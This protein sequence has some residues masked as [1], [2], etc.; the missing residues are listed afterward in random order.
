MRPPPKAKPQDSYT[1]GRENP[2]FAGLLRG[3]DTGS[4]SISPSTSDNG[5]LRG[6]RFS[7]IP[8]NFKDLPAKDPVSD[9]LEPFAQ[10]TLGTSSQIPRS[11][12]FEFQSSQSD[13]SFDLGGSNHSAKESSPDTFETTG[14]HQ[15]VP[16]L[17]R[18][19]VERSFVL[20][21]RK[22]NLSKIP[23]PQSAAT[24]YNGF[25]PQLEILESCESTVRLNLYLKARKDDVSA[26]VPG[27]FLHAV[28]GQDV[29][30]VGSIASTI[31]YALYLNET[32][33]SDQL[34]TVPIINMKRSG[35]SSHAEIKWLLDSCHIDESSL[36]FV[37]EID[38]SYFDLFGCLKLVLV[39]G[40]KLPTRQEALK[41][42]VIEVFNCRKGESVYPWVETVTIDQAIASA[43]D[44]SCCSLIAE[45]FFLTSPELLAGQG[46][47]RLLLAGILMDTGNLTSPHCTTKDKYMA[48][49]LLN[50][51]GRFGSS[52]LYQIMRYKMHDI[53]D[54]K[55]VDILR[56]DFKKWTRGGKPN[57][58][59]SR[60]V[61]SNI[62]MSSIGISLELFLAHERSSKEEIKY[63][64]Q[65]E[66]L[67]LLM[68]VS[69][70]YDDERNF[71]RE[72]LVSAESMELMRNL[73][74]FFNS[75]ASHMPLKAMHMSGLRDDMKAFEID[76]VTSRKTIERLLEEFGGASKG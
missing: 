48:T 52:G 12:S 71:K 51:A 11:T 27:K 25:S 4:K 5:D 53:S 17:S 56:K 49:L 47:S 1:R 34:C 7:D 46:F 9:I 40:H 45:K 14:E 39:N 28:I 13:V 26:G 75:N 29:S 23:L 54:L 8:G 42:A 72:V 36:L 55:V 44:C 35:L 57:P 60:L 58:T 37:D 38:L 31:M 30:D 68:I 15:A 61:V 64:Q 67:R 16:V 6:I 59:G 41:E 50:G 74:S 19:I 22:S 63:F 73:L 32:I 3:N 65:S 2:Y 62:G 69:G 21:K 18:P 24:F 10:T 43:Q 70:Y 33:K 66:K 76:K 20:N